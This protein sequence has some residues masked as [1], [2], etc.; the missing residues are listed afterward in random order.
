MV[1]QWHD[2]TLQDYYSIIGLCTT[3]IDLTEINLNQLVIIYNLY[4]D[5]IDLIE[6]EKYKTIKNGK[7]ILVPFYS[8]CEVFILGNNL[9]AIIH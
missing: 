6:I 1:L 8:R 4:Y 9:K 7:N 2:I 3:L 5:L